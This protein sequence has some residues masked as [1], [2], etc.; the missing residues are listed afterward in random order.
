MRI[1][2]DDNDISDDMA[3]CP[4]CR[5]WLM[6]LSKEVSDADEVSVTKDVAAATCIACGERIAVVREHM[7]RVARLKT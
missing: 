4:H 1:S 3:Q 6:D 2:R 7:Y 5:A